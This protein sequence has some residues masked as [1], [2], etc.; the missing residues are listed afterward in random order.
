MREATSAGLAQSPCMTGSSVAAVGAV[1]SS[2]GW[3]S[4]EDMGLLTLGSCSLSCRADESVQADPYFGLKYIGVGRGGTLEL[5]GQK[6]LS[7]TFLNKTLRPGGMEEGG[8]FFERSWGHRGVIVHVIDPK[9]ATVI[10]SDR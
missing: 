3:A 5:H 9:T 4:S 10:H 8:Y 6:K 2:P 1:Q 7:W